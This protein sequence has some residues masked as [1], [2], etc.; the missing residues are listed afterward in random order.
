[1]FLLLLAYFLLAGLFIICCLLWVVCLGK[2]YVVY[3]AKRHSVVNSETCDCPACRRKHKLLRKQEK[4]QLKKDKIVASGGLFDIPLFCRVFPEGLVGSC[5]FKWDGFCRVFE[6]GC[7]RWNE[8]GD[9]LDYSVGKVNPFK[10]G[11]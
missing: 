5:G 3:D 4:V 9:K 10:G 11:E 2:L 8:L 7:V 1:L 6:A